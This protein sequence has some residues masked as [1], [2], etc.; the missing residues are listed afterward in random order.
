M[1]LNSN[2][3]PI[4]HFLFSQKLQCLRQYGDRNGLIPI[5]FVV[6]LVINKSASASLSLGLTITRMIID[7]CGLHLVLLSLLKHRQGERLHHILHTFQTWKSLIVYIN[8]I[9]HFHLSVMAS[10]TSLFLNGTREF[11]E[12]VLARMAL[13]VYRSHSVLPL[14]L[15]YSQ[16]FG[17]LF[18]LAKTSSFRLATPDK[19]KAT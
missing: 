18:K 8:F 7:R 6:I 1:K 2:K 15:A 9:G 12:L 19:W 11:S 10:P 5:L 14:R 4:F 16:E 13:L 3:F 17:K